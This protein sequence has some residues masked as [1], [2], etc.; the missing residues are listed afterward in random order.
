MARIR[1]ARLNEA[2]MAPIKGEKACY[3]VKESKEEGLGL[4]TT[5]TRRSRCFGFMQSSKLGFIEYL[6]KDLKSAGASGFLKPRLSQVRKGRVCCGL[7]KIRFALIGFKFKS[8]LLEFRSDLFR[9]LRLPGGHPGDPNELHR[10][11]K[12]VCQLHQYPFFAHQCSNQVRSCIF[13]GTF[14]GRHR[15]YSYQD[16][17]VQRL[18]IYNF[19]LDVWIGPTGHTQLQWSFMLDSRAL[20]G[21]PPDWEFSCLGFVETGGINFWMWEH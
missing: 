1:V 15:K 20:D 5:R 11:D 4:K 8:T 9:F 18:P 17:E 12:P 13:S 6:V 3:R 14:I 16:T 19:K 2:V 7:G 21:V 10:Q